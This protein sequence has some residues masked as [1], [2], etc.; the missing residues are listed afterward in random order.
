[1][2]MI[3]GQGLTLSQDKFITFQL[4]YQLAITKI[5]DEDCKLAVE[6]LQESVKVC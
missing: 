1:M 2:C 4:L 5:A 6:T 3:N